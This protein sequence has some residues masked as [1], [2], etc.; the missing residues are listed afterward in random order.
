MQG[1]PLTLVVTTAD[2]R[3]WQGH[4]RQFA[5]LR[6]HGFEVL[7]T[8]AQLESASADVLRELLT[9]PAQTE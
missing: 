7:G 1:R 2:F 5:L 8:W 9:E 6:N 4:A 3:P